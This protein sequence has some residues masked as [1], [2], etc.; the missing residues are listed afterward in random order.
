VATTILID[1]P[2]DIPTDELVFARRFIAACRF[3]YAQSVPNSPHEYCPR[4]TIP[5]DHQ[6]DY[7]RF[8]ALIAQHGYRGRFLATTYTYLNCDGFRYWESPSYFP[9]GSVIINRA[10]NSRAPSLRPDDPRAELPEQ[11]VF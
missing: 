4:K 6:A 10:D 3:T 8:V 5:G 2:T 11:R 9:P 1:D 7:D